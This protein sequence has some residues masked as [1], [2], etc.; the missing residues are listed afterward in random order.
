MYK[1]LKGFN[2]GDRGYQP[3]ENEC[4]K[5]SNPERVELLNML[6]KSNFK[7]SLNKRGPHHPIKKI[8]RWTGL[9]NHAAWTFYPENPE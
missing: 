1:T 9:K 7:Q 2:V 5:N 8:S 4:S 6:N 3:T